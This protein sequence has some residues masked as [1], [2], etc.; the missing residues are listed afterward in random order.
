MSATL[1]DC[2]RLG[3]DTIELDAG[4]LEIP[5]ETLLRY[6]HMIKE[7]GLKVK[8][9]FAVKFDKSDIPLS[10]NRAYGAYVK[11]RPRTYGI[12]ICL[13]LLFLCWV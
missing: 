9:Q 10:G 12:W 4:S 5:E 13:L 2:K 3:F 7:T 11:P 1:Q 6:V 8:P